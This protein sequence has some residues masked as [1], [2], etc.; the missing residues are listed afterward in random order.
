MR[1]VVII[2]GGIAGSSAALHLARRGASVTLVER[3]RCGAQ[4]SGVNYGGVRQQGRI[5]VELPLA[6]RSRGF[7]AKLPE[8]IGTD[9]EFEVSGHLRIARSAE[10]MA[11]LE[12]YQTVAR[13]HGLA[14]ELLGETA[15][16]ERHPWLGAGV[17][18]GSYCAEDGQA[19]PRVVSPAIARAAARAGAEIL[20]MTRVVAAQRMVEGFVVAVEGGPEIQARTLINAAGA[21]AGEMATWF[22]EPVP[23]ETIAPNMCV[24]EPLPRRI[25]PNIGM[26]GAGIYLRQ[27]AR[28]NV[29][30]GGGRGVADTARISARPLEEST[31]SSCRIAAEIAPH[32]ADAQIIRTWTGIEGN[33]PD[34]LPVL[35]PSRTTAGL[36]HAFGFSGHG[37][38][39]GLGVGAVLADL[40]LDGRTETPIEA[41]AVDRFGRIT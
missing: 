27:I 4:A 9:G 35:G 6:R 37:F 12:A 18:G 7:W 28:G 31:R 2:G 19:N 14:L 38:Q 29:V 39:L 16:R 1:D 34:E 23:I 30:F 10:Q 17:V 5:P 11:T 13:E 8:L 41:F 20:E 26:V 40:A 22:G 33:M 15:V 24:T 3:G 21:W 32:L 36:L 25:G